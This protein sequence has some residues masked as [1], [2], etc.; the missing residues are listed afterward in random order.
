I[1]HLAL[2]IEIR[3]KWKRGMHGFSPGI[4]RIVAIQT[5]TDYLGLEVFETVQLRFIRRKLHGTHTAEG[6]G[7]KGK[8]NIFLAAKIIHVPVF[9]ICGFQGEIWSDIS[10]LQG[11]RFRMA[12]AAHFCT[13]FLKNK[14]WRARPE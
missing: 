1:N 4:Q 6:E 3:E 10:Y 2:G 7:H 14:Y 13:S 11:C 12:V 8:Y 5:Y 9:F